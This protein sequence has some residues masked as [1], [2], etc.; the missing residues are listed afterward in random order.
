MQQQQQQ[1]KHSFVQVDSGNKTIQQVSEIAHKHRIKMFVPATAYIG[2]F[3]YHNAKD[4]LIYTDP[5]TLKVVV[6]K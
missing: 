6:K 3:E 2:S 5:V 4:R 1:E